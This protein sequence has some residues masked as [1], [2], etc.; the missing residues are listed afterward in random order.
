MA[1]ENSDLGACVDEAQ[2]DR[3]VVLRN[4]K[5]VAL[6]VGVE[7]LDCEQLDLGSSDTF[8]RLIESRRKEKTVTRGELER[9]LK[10]S[11][12]ARRK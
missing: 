7:G 8:W 9:R 4:R 10:R 5:P 1:L 11:G 2:R 6:I 12:R 3:V